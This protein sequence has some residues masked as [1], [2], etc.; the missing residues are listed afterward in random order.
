MIATPLRL[1]CCLSLGALLCPRLA[2][3]ATD[4]LEA[5]QKSA[6]EWVKV[7]AETVRL[8]SE[9]SSDRKLLESTVVGLEERAMQLEE[10]RDNA[11]AKTAKDRDELD[12]MRAK[13]KAAADDLQATD[14]QLKALG[15]QLIQLRPMLP[16]RLSQALEMSFR[17]L[18]AEKLTPSER[19]QAA[20]TILNRCAQFN[21]MVTSG[22]EVLSIDGESGAKS[23]EVI[24]WGLSHAYAL[25]REARKAWFGSPGP[26]GWQWELRPDTTT[27]VTRLIAIYNDKSDP[28]F[29]AAP[30]RLGHLPAEEIQR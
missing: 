9:W 21:R 18:A 11:K 6:T 8:E 20:T 28:E 13:N 5:V 12:A 25:D 19:M 27:V 10:K 30:A 1:S 4:P 29:V 14:T 26:Q 3:A 7:R 22:E 17:S 16:P 2:P 15:A 23:L 24:Y